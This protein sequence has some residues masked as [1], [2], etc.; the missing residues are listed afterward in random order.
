MRGQ[1]TPFACVQMKQPLVRDMRVAQ[2][3]N[4][5]TLEVCPVAQPQELVQLRSADAGSAQRLTGDSFSQDRH[6]VQEHPQ[7]RH[8]GA[9]LDVR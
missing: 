2:V 7:D 1:D 9:L 4:P 3:F 6:A 5:C 8:P